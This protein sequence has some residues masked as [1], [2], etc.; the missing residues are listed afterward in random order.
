MP[1]EDRGNHKAGL[2]RG[3]GVGSRQCAIDGCGQ[4][5]AD[6]APDSA[7]VELKEIDA[8]EALALGSLCTDLS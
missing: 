2:H 3:E 6:V 4:V 8:S 5:V 1:V 7:P